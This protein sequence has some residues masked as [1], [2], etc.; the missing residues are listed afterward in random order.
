MKALPVGSCYFPDVERALQA[1]PAGLTPRELGY[2]LRWSREKARNVLQ[3]TAARG[4]L[5]R[6]RVGKNSWR[7]RLPEATRG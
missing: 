6:E 2:R 4:R 7:Y 1:A 5:T 3:R